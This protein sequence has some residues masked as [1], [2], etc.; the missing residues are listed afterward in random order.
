[1]NI[2][3]WVIQARRYGVRAA[4]PGFIACKL[5][6]DLIFVP[7]NF[8][9]Y[10]YYSELTRQGEH[11]EFIKQL[12]YISIL[13]LLIFFP[14]NVLV[15]LILFNCYLTVFQKYDPEFTATSLDEAYL[16]ITEVCKERGATGAE[17]RIPN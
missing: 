5:C 14:K 2:L 7:I 17:V 6:P 4:M 9:K 1:M 16:N 15:C 3:I 13:Q 12:E 10:T 8:K 11:C